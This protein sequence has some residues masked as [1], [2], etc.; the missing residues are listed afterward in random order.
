[1]DLHLTAVQ[2]HVLPPTW[3]NDSPKSTNQTATGMVC[4]QALSAFGN[5]RWSIHGKPPVK[6]MLYT[7]VFE[8]PTWFQLTGISTAK[9]CTNLAVTQGCGA[10]NLHCLY[11]FLGISSKCWYT[12]PPPASIWFFKCS[13]T[14]G[15]VA[16]FFNRFVI[17]SSGSSFSGSWSLNKVIFGG[18]F[19]QIFKKA[20]LPHWSV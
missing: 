10:I 3:C 13:L 18:F 7:I 2:H 17:L 1:M 19:F 5:T 16:N 6:R 14:K 11:L 4:Y 15:N 12:L 9:H 20:F 8:F